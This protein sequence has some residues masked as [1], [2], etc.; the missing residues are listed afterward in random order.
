[1]DQ[2]KIYIRA[3]G[4]GFRTGLGHL[5][6]CLAIADLFKSKNHAVLFICK[7]YPVALK[8]LAERQHF[9]IPIPKDLSHEEDLAL[10]KNITK[11]GDILILDG[12][13]WQGNSLKNLCYSSL[14]IACF[15]DLFNRKLPLDIV[16]AS[17]YTDDRLYQNKLSCFTKLIYGLQYLPLRQEFEELPAHKISKK[18]N[19]VL[20]NFGG[21]DPDNMTTEI[22]NSLNNL[23]QKFSIHI[24]IGAAFRHKEHLEKS[25]K[26]SIHSCFI[27]TN[28]K[29]TTPLLQNID[30]AI[31]A[32]GSTTWELA[33]AGIP[34][35]LISIALNQD[36]TIQ[37]C[38]SQQ[39]AINLD[40]KET[41]TLEKALEALTYEKR[42]NLSQKAQ[43]LV[44][45][46][47][48]IRLTNILLSF[49]EKKIILRIPSNDPASLESLLIWNWR[50]D[51][52]TK[53]MSKNGED[54][55]WEKHQEWFSLIIKD[56]DQHLFIAYQAGNPIGTARLTRSG[57][58][59][60]I[61]I[62][63]NPDNRGKGLGKKL[64]EE[65]SLYGF[66][67]LQLDTLTAEIKKG[68]NASIKIFKESGF[69]YLK[70][71]DDNFL[72]FIKKAQKN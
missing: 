59:A 67:T 6:R 24:L 60:K 30:L 5:M 34:M 36:H 29:K 14:L 65:L 62:N 69:S 16:I 54:I 21:E 8:L 7:D 11:D 9:V 47:G 49:Y 64:L 32:G 37:Y 3:D 72:F 46:K 28:L 25:I 44:D 20:L 63:L 52:L 19:N 70:E 38:V 43:K 22:L 10:T 18:I 45:G 68:N 66:K 40:E 55:L 23:S 33:A 2:L 1:M 56:P 39:I 42:L 53:Q 27:Y 15:D 57:H 61:S 48:S 50:N 35:I 58:S 51:E 31:T 41:P 71:V 13:E 4:G 12:Y 26:T 17:P